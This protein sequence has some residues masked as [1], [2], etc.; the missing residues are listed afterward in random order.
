MIPFILLWTTLHLQPTNEVLF[1]FDFFE[2][3]EHADIVHILDG[4]PMENASAVIATLS[5]AEDTSDLTL[6]SSTNMLTIKFRSDSAIQTR[7]FQATWRAG[8]SVT[9]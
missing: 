5:G 3:E 9:P 6:T 8:Q 4:G 1:Q 2:T 7:G